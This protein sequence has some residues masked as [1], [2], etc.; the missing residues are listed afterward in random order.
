MKTVLLKDGNLI[1][2]IVWQYAGGAMVGD[3]T[4]YIMLGGRMVWVRPGQ[5][6]DFL[7][8]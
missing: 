5:S 8:S 3:P 6:V 2:T 7:E 1:R 4:A